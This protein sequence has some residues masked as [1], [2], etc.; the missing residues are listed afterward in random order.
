ME[1][2]ALRHEEKRQ[3]EKK[4][5]ATST[6]FISLPLG[7]QYK[8]IV[9]GEGKSVVQEGQGVRVSYKL[10]AKHAQGKILD[11]SPDYHFCVGKGD[12]IEGWD[13]G[14]MG[15]QQGG[16]RHLIVP[17][18]TGYGRKDVG[19]GP[20]GVLYFEIALLSTCDGLP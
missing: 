15:M 20:G 19:A 18:E 11:A 9:V 14:L 6:E 10:R 17:P 1:R 2:L 16:L 13:I 8:D 7:V 4:Q 5:Q 3:L 12:V